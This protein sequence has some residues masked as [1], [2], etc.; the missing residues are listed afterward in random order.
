MEKTHS[1][2]VEAIQPFLHLA[3]STASPSPRFIANLI[4]NAT[5][6]PNTYVFAELLDTTAVQSLRSPEIPQEYRATL[7]LLETFAWGTW[8]DYHG[9]LH[10]TTPSLS[11]QKTIGPLK[12]VI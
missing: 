4:T 12:P 7:T 9:K 2:A 3:A 5:S 10:S 6:A 11:I 1:R 8:Q